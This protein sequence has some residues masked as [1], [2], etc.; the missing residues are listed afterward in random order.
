MNRMPSSS[1]GAPAK[2]GKPYPPDF[3]KLLPAGAGQLIVCGPATWFPGQ[4][5]SEAF[6]EWEGVQ[7]GDEEGDRLAFERWL[8][9]KMH[10]RH[11]ALTESGLFVFGWSRK[12]KCYRLRRTILRASLA[13]VDLY[14]FGL[15]VK[16]TIATQR[17]VDSFYFVVGNQVDRAPTVKAFLTLRKMLADAKSGT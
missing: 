15:A 13:K 8:K 3:A 6:D 7:E 4:A 1:P 14:A 5:G 9:R 2:P 10:D 17:S 12:E 11:I 16:V